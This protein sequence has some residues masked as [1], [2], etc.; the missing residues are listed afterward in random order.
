MKTGIVAAT[1]IALLVAGCGLP[2]FGWMSGFDMLSGM[3]LMGP[4]AGGFSAGEVEVSPDASNGE[5]IFKTGINI[6]GQRVAYS[7][8]P[9]WLAMHGGGCAACHGNDGTGGLAVMPTSL[10]APDIRYDS[11][12]AEDHD[13]DEQHV[14]YD[15]QSLA[16]AIRE[17]IEPDGETLSWPMPRWELSDRDMADLIDYLKTLGAADTQ[18]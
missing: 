3:G 11:L 15:E 4:S 18:S 9:G 6:D 1:A 8:G 2:M 17:G 5:L 14:P 12:T 7:G 16:R 13:G 10:I